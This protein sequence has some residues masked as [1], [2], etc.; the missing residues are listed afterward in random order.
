MTR[1][2]IFTLLALAA[3]MFIAGCASTTRPA[4]DANSAAVTSDGQP[5]TR[6]PANSPYS[7]PL[8]AT[9]GDLVMLPVASLGIAGRASGC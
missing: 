7:Q 3:A 6:L 5:E 8:M 2:T 1:Q 9:G 4:A